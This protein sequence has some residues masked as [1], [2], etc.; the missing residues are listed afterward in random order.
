[1]PTFDTPEPISVTLEPVV[2][3]VRV[4]ATDRTDTV[5][6]VAPTDPADA[7]DVKAA[8]QTRVEFTAGTL[9]VKGP[10]MNLF[11][12]SNRTR[13][14]DVLIEL[15][16]GSR[17]HGSTGVGDLHAAGRLGEV[18][19]KSGT[20][21]L[22]LEH[23]GELH[24]HTATGNVVVEQVAGSAEVTSSSGRIQLVEIDGTAQVKNSNGHTVLGDVAGAVRVRAANGDIT[25][26]RA[27]DAVDAK[28]ANGSVRV[29]EVIRGVAELQTSMGD[30]EVGVRRGSAAWLDVKTQFGRVHN[31]MDAVESPD[32]AADKVEVRANT[33]FGEITIRHS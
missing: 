3:N 29:N 16:A 10:R 8:E 14:I 23:T 2:G 7:S 4:V 6:H 1:M 25:V 26:E 11:D 31:S 18:R 21:H 32:T 22:Q 9:T 17:V 30:I 15:P 24:L 13:S 19:Y 28:T 20:G 5:V 27:G 12:F 33:S